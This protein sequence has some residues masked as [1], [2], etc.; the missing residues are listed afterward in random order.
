MKIKV[1]LSFIITIALFAFI[2]GIKISA[3]EIYTIDTY[4]EEEVRIKMKYLRLTLN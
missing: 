3:S 1:I 4:D 2:S